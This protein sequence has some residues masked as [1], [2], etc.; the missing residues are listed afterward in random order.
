MVD[1]T[2]ESKSGCGG[3]CAHCAVPDVVIDQN[4][5]KMVG[6]R[7]VL[8]AI[9]VFLGPLVCALIG[10]MLF[11]GSPGKQTGGTFGGLFIGLLISIIT[12]FMLRKGRRNG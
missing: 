5:E 7:L 4:G 8:P 6:W 1:H 9:G 2:G 11:A 10:A 3:Q 12:G